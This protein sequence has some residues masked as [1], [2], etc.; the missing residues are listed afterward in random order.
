MIGLQDHDEPLPAPPPPS[1][2]PAVAS[3]IFNATG[4][5]T[6]AL[7]LEHRPQQEQMAHAVAQ[8]LADDAP[9]LFEAGTGVGKSLAYL[10]PGIAHAVAQGR[11]L[12]VS[13]HTIALQEQLDRKDLPLCRRVY[14][15]SPATAR[16]ADFKSTVLL[17]KANYCCTS[18]LAAALT[19]KQGLLPG[20]EHAELQRVTDWAQTTATG[21]KHELNPP[22]SPEVWDLV[23]ADSAG[24]SRKYCD[25]EKC[26]Y[27]KARAR[28]RS[29]HVII[30]NHALL[31]ALIAAGGAK[32]AGSGAG[33]GVLFPDDCVV[34]DEAHTVPEVATDYFGLRLSSYGVERMLRHLFNPKSKRGVLAR[35]FPA[36]VHQL[37][38]DALEAA[39]QF[40]GTLHDTFLAQQSVVRIREAGCVEAW[41]DGPLLAIE[42][43]IRKAVD[44]M[45]EGRGRD[46]LMEQA[47]KVRAAQTGIHQFLELAEAKTHVHWLERLGRKQNIV[48]LRTAPIEIAPHLREALFTRGTSVVLASATLAAA[49][50]RL[51][52]FQAR[53]GAAGAR[54]GLAHSPFDFARHMRVYVATDVPLPDKLNA[55]LALDVLA[56]Y[57]DFCCRRVRGGSLVL[58]TSYA[59]MQ[60]VAAQLE[61][62]FAGAGRPFFIQGR[63]TSR[64]EL[65][66]QL[67]RA[68]NGILFGTDSFWTGI[69]VPGD[70]LAQ[71]ILTRLPFQVPTHP[72]L[73]ARTEAVE[74]RGGQP[75]AEITLPDALMM[76]RQGVGRLIRSATDRGVITLL[77]A[78]LVQKTYGRQFLA[79]L[80]QPRITRMR[81]DNRLEVFQP[82]D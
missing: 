30:V 46:E 33:K 24:C 57:I 23:N 52:P 80:P 70:A 74:A 60:R 26:F 13:T 27:Q 29:A 50:D 45:E 20:F 35:T 54:T 4:V 32:A 25:H 12:V 36:H 11:Q 38:V 67:R 62:V 9:L 39:H 14:A 66:E 48:A 51:E 43:E 17:G 47:A 44:R 19:D 73:A 55:A 16:Y 10:L 82:Y 22:P 42:K 49:G 21:L 63:D 3:A 6:S 65:T 61:P 40:F 34:L 8:A 71:V 41:L 77:D 64:T 53:V 78:R 79:A 68:G 69:D 58:F 15:A 81:Q 72:V 56:D 18:R 37:V 1:P 5:L 31:F 76:F 28:V 2:A 75:F 7:R 59:D